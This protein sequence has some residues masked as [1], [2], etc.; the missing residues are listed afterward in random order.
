MKNSRLAKQEIILGNN[1]RIKILNTI[2]DVLDMKQTVDLVEK[3]VQKNTSSS[4][5]S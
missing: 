1:Q 2:I 5:R 3:Y 4:S